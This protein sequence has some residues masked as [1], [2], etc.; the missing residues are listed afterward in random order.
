MSE[1][2]AELA[3]AA[4]RRAG[5]LVAPLLGLFLAVRGRAGKEERSRRD[6]RHGLAAAARPPGPLV[7]VHAASVGETLAVM[8]LVERL[9]GGGLAVLLTT[10]TVTSAAIAAG[11]L[12]AGAIHQYVPLDVSAWIGR[13]LDHWRPSLAVFVE[14]EIWPATIH[15]LTTRAIPQVL[16]NARVSERSARRWRLLDGLPR[17]LF[18]RFALTLAQSSA[19]AERLRGLGAEPVVVTGNLKFDGA[20]LGVDTAELGRLEAAIGDRST[21]IAAS[22]HPGEEAIV[23]A[24][25]GRLAREIPGLLTVLAPRHPRRGD[26]IRALLAEAGV[27]VAS[28]SLGETPSGATD[29]YLADTIGEMGLIYRLAP[30]AFVG[31]S[32]VP[33]GGQNPIEPAHLGTAV[34][35]GPHVANF[36]DLYREL[37][38]TGG[39]RVVTGLDDLVAA[40]AAALTDPIT[41]A[42]C[43]ELARAV[44]ERSSGSLDRTVAALAPLL[45]RLADEARA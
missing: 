8:G 37:D 5:G 4:Y 42:T 2:L 18:G 41:A 10:G 30:V 7:W 11:R 33:H 40:V 34:L 25:H 44:V 24:A 1:A 13:F 29:V 12:P 14:S 28:R 35:H 36:R 19:D 27:D 20:A 43:A 23:A 39:A 15:Q 22:T 21:W 31:G 3:L 26:E 45:A 9:A 17:A 16:V 6:E 32:L 38:E